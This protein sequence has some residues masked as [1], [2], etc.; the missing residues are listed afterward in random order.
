MNW[1][2]SIFGSGGS[3]R[4]AITTAAPPRVA[5][6]SPTV[7]AVNAGVTHQPSIPAD[8]HQAEAAQKKDW[9][10][11]K[12]PDGSVR[13]M[14][15]MLPPASLVETEFGLLML[16]ADKFPILVMNSWC[17]GPC[18]IN[19]QNVMVLRAG[20]FAA[21][22]KTAGITLALSFCHMPSHAVLL[23][24]VRIEATDLTQAVRA[25]YKHVPPLAKPMA[26]WLSGLNP[27][28]QELIPTVLQS[29][30]LRVVITEDSSSRNSVYMP[31]G[32]VRESAMPAAVGEFQVQLDEQSRGILAKEWSDLVKFAASIP[33]HRR[34]FQKATNSELTRVLPV[35]KDPIFSR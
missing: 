4:T 24:D 19:G 7:H 33:A 11:V 29:S 30:P 21:K 12:S 13:Q 14:V 20:A 5:A 26:E 27:Y 32:A 34:D 2:K 9:Y 3:K 15:V 18:R 22:V 6:A 10:F 23:A 17:M 1:L 28:D 16:P 35:D 31:N 8:S 25:Q